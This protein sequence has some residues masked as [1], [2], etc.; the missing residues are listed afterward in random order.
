MAYFDLD[1]NPTT[2][3]KSKSS[4]GKTPIDVSNFRPVNKKPIGND[5][6][7]NPGIYSHGVIIDLFLYLITRTLQLLFFSVTAQRRL[8]KNRDTSGSGYLTIPLSITRLFPSA[9][10][11]Y[12]SLLEAEPDLVAIIE[13]APTDG[14]FAEKFGSSLPEAIRNR[15]DILYLVN[16]MENTLYVSINGNDSGGFPIDETTTEQIIE[17]INLA[18]EKK[19]AFFIKCEITGK[20]I[21][22][23][24]PQGSIKGLPVGWTC[25]LNGCFASG[26]DFIKG[27]WKCQGPESKKEE[28][29]KIVEKYY[30]GFDVHIT[31]ENDSV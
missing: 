28:A 29:Y 4:G 18:N 26:S 7:V 13:L 9:L 24:W 31:W 14:I 5:W 11:H 22:D 16:P 2:S 15:N 8:R 23:K 1:T 12:G 6:D 30:D 19:A 17:Y 27:T 3:I 25:E 20:E 21:V 10:T